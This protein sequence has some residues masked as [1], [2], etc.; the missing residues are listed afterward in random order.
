MRDCLDW[1]VII[2]ALILIEMGR[3][4]WASLLPGFRIWRRESELVLEL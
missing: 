3:P 2:D 1:A 4:L